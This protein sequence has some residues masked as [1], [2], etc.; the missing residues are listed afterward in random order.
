VAAM[1]NTRASGSGRID[2]DGR[3]SF[4]RVYLNGSAGNGG[5]TLDFRSGPGGGASPPL[6]SNSINEA[7]FRAMRQMIKQRYG[8]DT[9]SL[10]TS[11]SRQFLSVSEQIVRGQ[12]HLTLPNGRVRYFDYSVKVNPITGATRDAELHLK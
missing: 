5:F 6:S 12:G 8:N 10:F 1:G 4:D 7:A 3:G 9:K 2:L 11:A